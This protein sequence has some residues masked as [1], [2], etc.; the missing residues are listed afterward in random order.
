[1]AHPTTV[2]DDA[3]A[4]DRPV[5]LGHDLHQIT[6][7]FDGILL[8]RPSPPAS[9]SADMRIDC[10]TGD[11]EG[12]AEHHIRSFAADPREFDELFESARNVAVVVIHQCASEPLERL[13]LRTVK[14]KRPQDF[15]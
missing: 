7:G 6:L 11:S 13:R 5:L 10:N 12:S 1:M 8:C 15:F 4:V 14:T 2:M 9:E 3:V